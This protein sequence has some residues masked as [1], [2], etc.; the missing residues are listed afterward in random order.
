MTVT[1]L[2]T[3]FRDRACPT[4]ST[5]GV[6]VCE[7]GAPRMHYESA[8]SWSFAGCM[9]WR[10]DLR[11][12]DLDAPGAAPEVVVGSVQFLILRAGYESPR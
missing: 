5:D 3:F 11:L 4:P 9:E 7:F 12:S 10:A 6:Q 2:T 8:D 1:D